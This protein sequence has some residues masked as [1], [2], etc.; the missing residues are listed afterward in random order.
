MFG[1]GAVQPNRCEPSTSLRKATLM[2]SPEPLTSRISGSLERNTR[3]EL[4]TFALARPPEDLQPEAY[5]AKPS[6]SLPDQQPAERSMLSVDATKCS[7]ATDAG[8]T[9]I[10]TG[11][12]ESISDDRLFTVAQVAELLQVR[13]TDVYAACD[14][15][16][17]QYVRFEGAV[18]IEG[19]DLKSWAL[20]AH[21]SR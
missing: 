16:Q 12:L 13:K 11:L 8:L 4:A 3:F 10:R 20:N 21:Q 18:Q 1:L 17:L 2:K 14:R 15:G 6:E 19:R 5:S 9:P 7:P